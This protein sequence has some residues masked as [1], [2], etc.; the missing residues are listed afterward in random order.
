MSARPAD[1]PTERLKVLGVALAVLGGVGAAVQSRINGTL[2]DRLG[3]GFG[4][5][6][7]SFGSGLVVL[8]IV[9]AAWPRSRAAV[10][11]VFAGLR[12]AGDAGGTAPDGDAPRLRWWECVGGAAGG[13]FVATQG[14]TV[15]ALG[16]AVFVVA[17]VAG[18]SVSSLVVDRL[19]LAPGGVRLI[20]V[21]RA[22]GPALTVVAVLVSVSG[23]LG[24]PAAIGL[25][26]LP[27]LAGAGSSWQQAVNGR[28]RAVAS[29]APRGAAPG[30]VAATFL[31]FVVGTVVLVVALGVSLL[32]QGAPSGAFPREP[33]LYVGGLIGIAF[34]AIS[35]AIVH[36]IGVLLLG[37]GM[38]AGQVVGALV[39]DVVTPGAQRPGVATYVGAALTLV[40][41]AVPALAG[42]RRR[43]TVRA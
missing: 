11:R 25:A 12:S 26:V 10:R 5:A 34:I 2:A 29:D 43:G 32:V 14:L 33:W 35:A 9:V 39:L 23:Q 42:R 20:T 40:A 21:D 8:A 16:V 38:I 19:G 3:S 4:A 6:V 41:V 1:P 36:R 15:G 30:V 27:V 37:L 22:L 18:Q 24:S 28:V 31:N 7:V 17:V 13:F